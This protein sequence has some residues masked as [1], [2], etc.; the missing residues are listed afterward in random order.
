[1]TRP[2]PIPGLAWL[3]LAC[4]LSAW[5]LVACDDGSSP[6]EPAPADPPAEHA[7]EAAPAEQAGEAAPPPDS[8][9]DTLAREIWRAAGGE[10]FEDVQELRFRFV[11]TQG[12]DEVFSATHRW[13]RATDR[14]HVTWTDSE[15]RRFE[16][17]VDLD[18]RMACGTI[19]GEIAAGETQQT[20]SE[21]AYARWVNDAY[22]L[23]M[24]LK[25]LDPGV[26]RTLEEPREH[27]GERYQILR[28][29]F[30]GVG[31]TPGDRYWLFV[32]P[33]T[34][35]VARW[36]MQLEGQEGP[37]KGMS[38]TDWR[39]VGPLTLA[40]DHATDDGSRHV[41]LEDVEAATTPPGE[42]PRVQG[43]PER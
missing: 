15:G 22:W 13:D 4:T 37:P 2:A 7:G 5:S 33:E 12:D 23:V 29:S 1:M 38:W 25:V 20:L 27:D 40:M 30:E 14:D 36:E 41:R 21:K 11:V 26:V 35:R 9:A 24:P 6:D 16:A 39:S 8:P 10:S 28:L 32:D 19:D 18:A 17:L 43:C 3:V 31:L 42:P 34:S